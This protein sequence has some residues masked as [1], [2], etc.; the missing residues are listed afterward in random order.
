M[1]PYVKIPLHNQSI[2]VISAYT[3]N[4]TCKIIKIMHNKI[5]RRLRKEISMNIPKDPVILLSYI[6]TKL[7]D[8]YPSLDELC[9]SLNIDKAWL[10]STLSS[11]A[12]TYDKAKNQFISA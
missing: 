9:F 10:K 4:P 12:Y 7:R 11:I 3:P 8:E 1:V 5:E 6:N 2:Y